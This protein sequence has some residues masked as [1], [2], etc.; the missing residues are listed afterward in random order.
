[1]TNANVTAYTYTYSVAGWDDYE[2]EEQAQIL[3]DLFNGTCTCEDSIVYDVDRDYKTVEIKRIPL[4]DGR[5]KFHGFHQRTI[6]P[7]KRLSYKSR[8]LFWLMPAEG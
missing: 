2:P 7:M 1:M 6:E 4:F 8:E 5:R 3:R